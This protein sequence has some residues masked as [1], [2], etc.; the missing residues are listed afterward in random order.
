MQLDERDSISDS[1]E[2]HFRMNAEPIGDV[3]RHNN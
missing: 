1:H 2:F 3:E